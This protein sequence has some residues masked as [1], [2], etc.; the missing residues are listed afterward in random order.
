[1]EVYLGQITLYGLNFAPR[2][3]AYC[4]GQLLSIAQNTALFSLLG[5][6]YGGNGQTTFGLP[7]LRGRVAIGQGTGPGL[8]NYS[9]GEMAGTPTTT[10]TLVNMPA[11]NHTLGGSITVAT[12]IGTNSTNGTKANPSGNT[13]AKGVDLSTSALMANFTDAGTDGGTLANVTSTATNGLVVGVSGNNQ[14]FGIMQPYLTLNYTIVT[15]GIFPPR[16]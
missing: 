2:G 4:Q 6:T 16:N 13:L 7:D 1:M 3:N 14:P 8:P 11:H 10:L 12:Q 15:E 5:T 9:L